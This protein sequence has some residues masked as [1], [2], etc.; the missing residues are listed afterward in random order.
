MQ[1]SADCQERGQNFAS[2]SCEREDVDSESRLEPFAEAQHA[3]AW[4]NSPGFFAAPSRQ[5]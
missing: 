4:D 5:R 2:E 1:Q 3:V